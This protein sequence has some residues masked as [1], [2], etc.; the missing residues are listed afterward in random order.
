MGRNG[1]TLQIVADG[2][3]ARAPY[4]QELR[5]DGKPHESTWLPFERI[6]KGATLRFKLGTTP[7]TRWATAPAAAPP[8]FPEG[9]ENTQAAGQ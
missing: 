6:A 2:A 5:L 3:S 9:M 1:K 7:H 4:V 8:S